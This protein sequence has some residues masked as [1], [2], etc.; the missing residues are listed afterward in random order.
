VVG[1]SRSAYRY[2]RDED[3][4]GELRKAIRNLAN[5][6]KR[7]GYRMITA[8]LRSAGWTVN[9]KKVHRI[10]KEEGLSLSKK[11]P[12]R[13]QYG[14]KGE[15]QKKPEYPN[16]VWSY[17]FVEDR[18][19]SNDRIRLL[20]VI[21][22]YTRQ[23]LRVLV[24]PR[25]GSTEVLVALRE[26]AVERGRPAFVRSDNGPE[27]VAGEVKKWLQSEGSETI[28][29]EPGSPWENGFIE[30][31]N[32]TLRNECLNMNIFNSGKEARMLVEEWVYEYNEYR[33]HSSLGYISPNEFARRYSG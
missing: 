19:S 30:S 20:C 2:T 4:D 7:E 17:D 15:I 8:R 32:G 21:D 31:F 16:H 25:L 29:I 6:N 23:A 5:R 11:R 22:E 24:A 1:I 13:R 28:Y 18:T 33:P 12:K 27:F 26:L 3:N 10:C 14:P 9:R